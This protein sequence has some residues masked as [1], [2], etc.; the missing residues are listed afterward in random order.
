MYTE[1]VTELEV[2]A[3]PHSLTGAG[4][5]LGFAAASVTVS[6]KLDGLQPLLHRAKD[7]Y[8]RLSAPGGL[9]GCLDCAR[10]E[11]L[12]SLTTQGLHG[13]AIGPAY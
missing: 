11:H 4:F 6:L 1:P 10:L 7:I 9:G 5:N 12:L 2:A 8:M 13:R 3:E